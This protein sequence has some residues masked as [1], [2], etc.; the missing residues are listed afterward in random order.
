MQNLTVVGWYLGR[1]LITH[2]TKYLCRYTYVFAS[3]VRIFH[4]KQCK[5]HTDKPMTISYNPLAGSSLDK[6]FY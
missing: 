5:V 6:A 3:E 1:Y 2:F 4:S